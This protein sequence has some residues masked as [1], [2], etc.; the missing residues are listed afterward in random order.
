M[1]ENIA[2]AGQTVGVR[3]TLAAVFRME[4]GSGKPDA[5]G[6]VRLAPR[7]AADA[8]AFALTDRRPD[9]EL[10]AR[11]LAAAAL[12]CRGARLRESPYP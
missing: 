6:R 9:A 3:Y 8:L 12:P 5:K 7:E 2:D 10:V 1:K 4:L 11:Q